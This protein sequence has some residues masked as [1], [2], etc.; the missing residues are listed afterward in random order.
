MDSTNI[1]FGEV[2]GS[3]TEG[4]L[5]KPSSDQLD[6]KVFESYWTLHE[7][8]NA[9]IFG[10]GLGH[11]FTLVVVGAILLLLGAG[12]W[13]IA[14]G[15]DDYDDS[16]HDAFW[17][18]WGVFFDPGTHTGLSADDA[19]TVRLVA[20]IFSICG[21]IFNLTL[22]GTVVEGV[23]GTLRN[24]KEMYSRISTR[25]HMLILG[26]GDKTLFLLSELLAENKG[27]NP[28]MPKEG[29]CRRRCGCCCRRR[30]K[31][32]RVVI[33]ADRAATDM[34]QEVHMHV[35]FEGLSDKTISYRE[36]SPTDRT[37]LMKVSAP[38]ARD[39]FIMG[40]DSSTKGSDNWITQTLL[41]LGALPGVMR[42]SG[43]VFAEM[44]THQS[45]RVA[46]TVLAR[47]EGIVARYAVNRMLVLRSIVPSV[48]YTYLQA[49][50]FRSGNEFYRICV[51]QELA[52]QRFR[53][54]CPLFSDGV[55][56]AV[57]FPGDALSNDEEQETFSLAGEHVLDACD[58]LLLL[59]PSFEDASRWNFVNPASQ[60]AAGDK[61]KAVESEKTK[62]LEAID[63]EEDEE[64]EFLHEPWELLK[65]DGQL[66]LGRLASGPK[67]VLLIG[68]PPDFPNVLLCLDNYLARGSEVHVL[69]TKSFE[70]RQETLERFFG[71]GWNSSID[72]DYF[73]RI[74]VNHHI[75]MPTCAN[76]LVL[77]PLDSADSALVLAEQSDEESTLAVDSQNL[78]VVI[79]LR[80]LLNEARPSKKCKIVTELLDAKSQQ[81][82]QRNSGVRRLGSFVYSNA[83]AT[84][85][86]ASAAAEKSV[87][88]VVKAL[89]DPNNNAGHIA[90]VPISYFCTGVVSLSFWDLHRKVWKS[91]GGILL[92]WRKYQDRYPKLNPVHKQELYTWNSALAD[93]L[94][95]LMPRSAARPWISSPALTP[96]RTGNRVSDAWLMP[97]TM[98][99][100]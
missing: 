28:F 40:S 27:F 92:G 53:D 98:S 93:E 67:V 86:F 37:E 29:C 83:L 33:L 30:H 82:L 43:E 5:G 79:C 76:D 17:I 8:F 31:A 4:F 85:V 97:N 60:S 63:G 61:A 32:P 69:S 21:F 70:W 72:Q 81:V 23:R 39:I 18:S 3:R 24:W 14:G 9:R 1:C 71:Q 34:A 75:G 2:G 59:A 96:P 36:G 54:V 64:E 26:W 25:D 62:S 41:A 66:Q 45:V 16:F 48:G 95:V 49:M 51:P 10:T 88:N 57:M 11:L 22:L 15:N 19:G 100:W 52:G 13:C 78:T 80:G 46:R 6:G 38:M 58:H 65:P 73:M 68:C 84:G 55:V 42:L 20:V 90:A 77:L 35:L 44:Q 7:D 89:L 91:C 87:Y 74:S 12:S 99:A 50:S 47:A 94:V 56:C